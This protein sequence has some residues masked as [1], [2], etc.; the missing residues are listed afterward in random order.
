M[1]AKGGRMGPSRGWDGGGLL[2]GLYESVCVCVCMLWRLWSA[3]RLGGS[4]VGKSDAFVLV[5]VGKSML[6]QK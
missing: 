6:L 4:W 1:S 3:W 2:M 5:D